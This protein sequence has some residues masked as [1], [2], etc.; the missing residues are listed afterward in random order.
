MKQG[1]LGRDIGSSYSC[2]VNKSYKRNEDR[3]NVA[4]HYHDN[5]SN[6]QLR[7]CYFQI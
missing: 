7:H 1:V 2:T 6:E 5:Y 4:A 3:S